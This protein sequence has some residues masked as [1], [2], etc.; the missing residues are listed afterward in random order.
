[1][2]NNKILEKHSITP[3]NLSHTTCKI[4]TE[5]VVGRLKEAVKIKDCQLWVD[6]MYSK[7]D[8]AN[9]A[10][11]I[12]FNGYILNKNLKK[13]EFV[14]ESI[15]MNGKVINVECILF[16]EYDKFDPVKEI[17]SYTIEFVGEVNDWRITWLEKLPPVFCEN[18]LYIQEPINLDKKL[19]VDNS[20]W[21]DNKMYLLL[22]KEA[23]DPLSHL[24]YARAIPRNI[25]FRE[26]H[27]M[28]ENASI[29]ANMMSLKIAF[30][31]SQIV[32][33]SKLQILG[34]LYNGA[35]G[36]MLVRLTRS[37]RDN[38]WAGKF[39]APWYGF[40]EM[41]S[42]RKESEAIISNCSSI[43]SV[44]FS[45]LRLAGFKLKELYKLRMHNQDALVANIDSDVYLFCSDK[46]IKL[47]NRTLYHTKTITKI[48]DDRWIWTSMGATNLPKK[49]EDK[50]LQFLSKHMSNF[51]FTSE[52]SL[53]L[54][55]LP[56]CEEDIPSLLD[57][58]DPAKLNSQ[59]K[60]YVLKASNDYPDSG[61][62]WAKYAYQ[63]LY[64]P[65]PETYAAWSVQSQA[66]QQFI[67]KYTDFQEL[68][69]FI[70]GIKKESIFIENDRIMTADQV[71]RHGSGDFKSLALFMYT[72]FKLTSNKGEF[73]C[74]SNESS[75][76]GWF[77]GVSW[78][79]WDIVNEK[80]TSEIQGK[81]ILA[82][83]SKCSYYPVVY[84]REKYKNKPL[85][86]DI[87]T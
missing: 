47:T 24:V 63:T 54:S 42:N 74:I 56:E 78:K 48:F 17:H 43:M 27:P 80:T 19:P 28:I 66:M 33:K 87:I 34:N 70:G 29:L 6:T 61:F 81:L 65:K 32:D 16:I 3:C 11:K 45:I 86:I 7:D 62:T 55:E 37:D 23:K 38:S 9:E 15:E 57:I 53:Q 64:V 36:R 85:W 10:Q 60:H 71:I 4:I 35:R 2:E 79:I 30:L 50:L 21:W 39:L 41:D 44:H 72:W 58:K 51:D 25:R 20:S 26:A 83:D 73:V 52:K 49:I 1:M 13:F 5:E 31:A 18:L 22:V 84:E 46:L 82:F 77:D 59:I 75:Y 68:K 14:I 76:C 69:K 12:W 40:D 8:L 67:R